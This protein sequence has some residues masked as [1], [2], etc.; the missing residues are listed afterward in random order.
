MNS[1]KDRARR[2][3]SRARPDIEG[4]AGVTVIVP[5]YKE[6]PTI[7]DTICSLQCQ[8]LQRAEIIVIDDCSTDQTG[9]VAA[10]LGASVVRP[11]T[12]TGSKAG[13]VPP[14]SD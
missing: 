7:A 9:E 2:A 12:N 4:G 5:A 10:A 14:G 6:E 1:R 13:V 11:P 8:T 3:P